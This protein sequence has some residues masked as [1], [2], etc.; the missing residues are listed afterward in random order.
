MYLLKQLVTLSLLFISSVVLAQEYIGNESCAECHETEVENWQPSHHAKAMQPATEANVLGNFSNSRFESEDG[1]TVFNYDENGFYI[2]TGP[3]GKAGIRY[4]VPY[5]FGY[6]PLQQ[7]LVD[8]GTGRLQAY[9]VAWDSRTK[10][11]GG[12]RWYNLYQQAHTPDTPFYWK[13]QFNNWNARC[14]EC[15]STELKRGYNAATDDYNTT[16]SEINVSCEACHGPASR[17]VTL[18]KAE[19]TGDSTSLIANS[20]FNQPLHKRSHWL[21]KEGKT[22]AER[23]ERSPISLDHGQPDQ[24]AA[25]HSRRVALTDGAGPHNF[26][27]HYIP[28]LAVPDLYHNDG[29]ILDEVYV[30][31]SFSQSKMA[32]AGVVCTNCHEPHSG[33][34]ISQDNSLCTQC[35]SPS[36][37]DTQEHTLHQAGSEGAVCIDCHMPSQR[38]MGVDDRRDHAYR[39]PNPWVSEALASPDVCLNCHQDKDTQWSQQQLEHKKAKVFAD[40]S[41]I[42][43]ALL[44]SQL[45]PQRGQENIATLVLDE[46]LPAMR[47]AVLLS[48]LD[49]SQPNNMAVLNS[50]AN[51]PQSLV[52]LGVLH[53]LES[54]PYN[55]QLQI[56]FGLLYDEDKNV[57]LQAI[58][59]LAPAFRQ[60][61][62]EKAQQPMQDAL[63]E[64]VVT[65]QQQQDLLSAQLALADLA[66]KV[67][68]TEQ[69]TI[70][71]INALKIQPSFLPAKLNLASIYRETSQLTKAQVL[72]Q[73]ILTIEP[74][75]AMALHNLGLIYVVQRQW[76]NALSALNMASELENDNRRFAYVYLLALEASGDITAAKRQLDK[77]ELMTPGDPALSEIRARLK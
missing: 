40:Y 66:Y 46:S 63:M 51:S 3:T 75:H 27:E 36:N 17:H 57:R 10:E 56:G 43:P 18:K 41:D 33:K 4:P 13:S 69:A 25:C 48:H 58:R 47:R 26:T 67:G 35:H 38:Y 32:A 16:W 11:Q 29:Q 22:S 74:K 7:I 15:H 42:G 45:A 59:L 60:S 49:V 62:P 71:Y 37:F 14:A 72:L 20:G 30:Y 50:A 53:A 54:A 12:Q 73:E 55:L 1:W 2:E 19:D 8:I 9:T 21:F 39:V 76:P 65:Y 5:V 61:L 52:K 64:A 70:Q 44:L 77:L 28:R 6:T 24:C 31:G 68:D 23:Y 34:V